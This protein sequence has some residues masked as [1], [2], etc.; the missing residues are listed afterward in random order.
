[1]KKSEIDSTSKSEP[2]SLSAQPSEERSE[3]VTIS[4]LRYVETLHV[5]SLHHPSFIYLSD[6]AQVDDVAHFADLVENLFE[7]M[8]IANV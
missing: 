6:A 3:K 4:R 7:L 8:A 1:M 2:K 5:T